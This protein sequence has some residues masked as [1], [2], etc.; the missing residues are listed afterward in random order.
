VW[1]RAFYIEPVNTSGDETAS[2]PEVAALPDGRLLCS[3]ITSGPNKSRKR[4]TYRP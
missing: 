1:R 4:S 2:D 3:Y